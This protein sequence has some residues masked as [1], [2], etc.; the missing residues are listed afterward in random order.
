M[1]AT[2]QI[3]PKDSDSA[4]LKLLSEVDTIDSTKQNNL[5]NFAQFK[6]GSHY[7]IRIRS[8]KGPI[9]TEQPNKNTKIV[10]R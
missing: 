7:A 9:R 5:C 10:T 2:G 3:S 6:S 4:I 1:P 8:I